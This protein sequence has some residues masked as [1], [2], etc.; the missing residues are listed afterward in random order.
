MKRIALTAAALFVVIAGVAAGSIAYFKPQFI[1]TKSDPKAAGGHGVPSYPQDASEGTQARRHALRLVEQLS[2]AQD[3]TI[4]GDHGALAEQQRLLLDIAREIR[5]FGPEEWSD[6]VNVR[7]SLLYVLSGGDANVVRPLINQ[8]SLSIA[9]ERLATGILSF[10][11]GQTKKA[12]SL[13]EGIDPRS[14]DVSL[15]GPFALARASLYLDDDHAKAISLLDEARLA[16][17]HTAIDEASIRRE[18]PILLDR[19]DTA[20]AMMLTTSYAREFGRSI[21]AWKL[22]RDLAVAIAKHEELDDVAT[23]DRLADSFNAA[24]MQPASELFVD[25]AGEA[26]LLGR[27]KLA[28]TAAA[29]A[30]SIKDISPENLEKAKLYAA[31]AVAP[32]NDAGNALKALDQTTV[33]RL[34]EDDTEIREVAGFIAKTVVGAGTENPK[35]LASASGVPGGQMAVP[36]PAPSATKAKAALNSADQILKEADSMISGGGK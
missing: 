4:R 29:A 21:Y 1:S 12:R 7:T 24:D 16:C 19:G 5:D 28:T 15:V 32:S 36:P 17:P 2:A 31:A 35:N 9:D 33:D 6:Y 27:L 22:F 10:A 11:E 30:M 14:L 18:I 13:F 25:L 26:L 34:S 23:V 8:T 3:K 20:R